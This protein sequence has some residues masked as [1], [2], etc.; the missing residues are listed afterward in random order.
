MYGALK[1]LNLQFVDFVLMELPLSTYA[2]RGDGGV[3]PKADIVSEV[4]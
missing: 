2:E 3:G 1:S 4:A